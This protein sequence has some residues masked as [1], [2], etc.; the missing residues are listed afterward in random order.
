MSIL[1]MLKP[2]KKAAKSKAWD[3]PAPVVAAPVVKRTP[4]K[5]LAISYPFYRYPEGSIPADRSSL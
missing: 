2:K 4:P 5:P 3:K 1:S